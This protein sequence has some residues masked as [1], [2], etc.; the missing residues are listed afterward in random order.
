MDCVYTNMSEC[1]QVP[2]LHP[3]LGLSRHAVV[4]CS[5]AA[6]VPNRSTVTTLSRRMSQDAKVRFTQ[7]PQQMNWAP[8]YTTETYQ[9]QYWVTRQTLSDTHLP[10]KT[11]TRFVTDKPW[12]L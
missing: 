3:G 1:Y 2:S 4:Y 9:E 5:P 12:I 7:S 11:T 8:I 10:V 6:V